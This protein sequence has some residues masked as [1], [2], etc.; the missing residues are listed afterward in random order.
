[1]GLTHE[2]TLLALWVALLSS[3]VASFLH[4]LSLILPSLSHSL[5]LQQSI[6][7]G[8]APL[9]FQFRNSS[10]SFSCVC[11]LLSSRPS[12]IPLCSLFLSAFFHKTGPAFLL[13]I[14]LH[15]SCS[16]FLVLPNFCCACMRAFYLN[17][18]RAH[19]TPFFPFPALGPHLVSSLVFVLSS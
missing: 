2:Q 8:S 12:P 10:G 6:F 17:P 11:S 5:G 7:L 9:L 16:L 19:L 15:Y 14:S 18:F 4:P 3:P 13:P 1:M